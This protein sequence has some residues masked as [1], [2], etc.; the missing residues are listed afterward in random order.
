MVE[1]VYGCG[2]VWLV[3]WLVVLSAVREVGLVF[4]A[5]SPQFLHF[6]LQTAPR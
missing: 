6:S 5:L 2:G 4:S 3:G 1:Y